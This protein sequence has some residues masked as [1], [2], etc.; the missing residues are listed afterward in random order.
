MNISVYARFRDILLKHNTKEFKYLLAI[1][2]GIDSM[3]LLDLFRQ[4]ST[5]F[6]V[7]HCNF[8]LRGDD[9]IGDE[10]FVRNYCAKN[11]IPFHSV[12]FNVDDYKKTGNYSTEMACRNLRYDWFEE[13]MKLNHL[14]YLVTAHHLNDNIE[15]FLINLSRGTGIKGLTGM[16]INKDN[17]FR[18]LIEFS[19]QSIIDYAESNQLKWREDYTNQTDDYVRN[20]IRHHI[21]PILNEVHPNFEDNFQKTLSILNDTSSFIDN[22]IEK[23]RSELISNESSCKISINKLENLQ[24]SDFILFYLFDKYGFNKVELIN[25][26]KVADN[27]SELKSETYRLIKDREDLILQK[28]VKSDINEI[29]IEQEQVEI[30]SLNLKFVQS[31]TKLSKAKEILDFDK[32]KYPLK[33]RKAQPA[34]FFYPLGMNGKKKLVSKFYK[35]IKLSKVEKE[36]TWLLVNADEKI[37]WIV[38]Y[39]LDERF[40]IEENSKNFLNIIEC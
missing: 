33:L 27:S 25:K 37:I 5:Q 7:A 18:P 35:D 10:E 4:T 14:D 36:D 22:Q 3:V 13:V 21:T 29:I 6:H 20:K 32:L 8:Q 1:S 16:A 34:D 39:R 11:L 19:K 12:R 9:S 2:G 17:I 28:I 38:N 24:N 26:L 23:I 40:K 31:N 30:N 15:T